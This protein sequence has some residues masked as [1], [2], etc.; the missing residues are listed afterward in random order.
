MLAG[1]EGKTALTKEQC[2]GAKDGQ[3]GRHRQPAYTDEAWQRLHPTQ[4]KKAIAAAAWLHRKKKRCTKGQATKVMRRNRSKICE[5]V[6][7]NT[8]LLIPCIS[9][10]TG[11][12]TT[13]VF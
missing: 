5:V 13:E 2:N 9:L 6:P 4:I 1:G 3:R 10:M 7:V 8:I 12:H 11:K